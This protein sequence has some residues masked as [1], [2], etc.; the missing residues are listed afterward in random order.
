M[1]IAGRNTQKFFSG[2]GFQQQSNKDGWEKKSAFI[3]AFANGESQRKKKIKKRMQRIIGGMQRVGGGSGVPGARRQC[4]VPPGLL[5]LVLRKSNKRAIIYSESASVSACFA[6]LCLAAG[7]GVFGARPAAAIV[8]RD[9]APLPHGSRLR[10]RFWGAEGSAAP[11]P[12]AAVPHWVQ[13]RGGSRAML[14]RPVCSP[15][16]LL[17][18]VPSPLRPAPLAEPREE[19]SGCRCVSCSSSERY[20]APLTLADRPQGKGQK[21]NCLQQFCPQLVSPSAF[22]AAQPASYWLTNI[23]K[24]NSRRCEPGGGGGGAKERE[25]LGPPVAFPCPKSRMAVGSRAVLTALLQ[26]GIHGDGASIAAPL[27][28]C[29]SVPGARCPHSWLEPSQCPTGARTAV[30]VLPSLSLCPQPGT[31]QTQTHAGQPIGTQPKRVL[32]APT[33]SAMTP[34]MGDTSQDTSVHPSSV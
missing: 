4:L 8:R 23:I 29:S 33:R 34:C 7:L 22:R 1:L 15:H 17:T 27:A 9:S 2:I 30:P 20:S 16:P 26:E 18:P 19:P 25:L 11:L 6:G 13:A 31:S 10:C 12:G 5:I 24:F 28:G 21:D 32:S 14:P 3:F